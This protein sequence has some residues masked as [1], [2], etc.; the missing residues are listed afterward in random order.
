MRKPE[1]AAPQSFT[2]NTLQWYEVPGAIVQEL[3]YPAGASRGRHTHYT[4]FISFVVEGD[5]REHYQSRKLEHKPNMLVL[6]PAGETHAHKFGESGGRILSIE[7]TPKGL[8]HLH[9][10]GLKCLTR[11]ERMDGFVIQLAHRL[12]QQIR[13]DDE[14]RSLA[15]EGLI[16]EILGE[17]LCPAQ[18]R[19]SHFPWMKKVVDYLQTNFA[20]NIE[21]THVAKLAGVHPVHL[22]RS[23][24]TVQGCTVGEHIRRLR[25]EEACKKLATSD[26]PVTVVAQDCG[27][28]D[29]SHFCRI[30]KAHAGIS[31]GEFRRVRRMAR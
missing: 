31:P 21:L 26:I 14:L 19:Y 7:M 10:R 20:E 2:G 29:H 13:L 15:I 12:F 3:W 16:L 28:F 8:E 4:T 1:D 25:I 5:Y 24:R 11:L 18:S 23:F 6:H 9:T 17:L 27:F 22:A 30:F